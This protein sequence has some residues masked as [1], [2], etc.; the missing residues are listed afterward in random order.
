MVEFR[1]A[2]EDPKLR[3]VV[4][5][6]LAKRHL[7]H[8]QQLR[9][10]CV[11]PIGPQVMSMFHKGL[12]KLLV[13]NSRSDPW[14]IRLTCLELSNTSI[15]LED[16]ALAGI[17]RAMECVDVFKVP[18]SE[19]GKLAFKAL[20]ELIPHGDGLHEQQQQHQLSL[21]GCPNVTSKMILELLE[22]SLRL[23]R[24]NADKVLAS[25]MALSTRDSSMTTKPWACARSLKSLRLEFRLDAEALLSASSALVSAPSPILALDAP[26]KDHETLKEATQHLQ[27]LVFRRLSEPTSFEVLQLKG[28]RHPVLADPLA[29]LEKFLNQGLMQNQVEKP[30]RPLDDQVNPALDLGVYK[31]K[32]LKRMRC[33]QTDTEGHKEGSTN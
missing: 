24:F 13:F 14:N 12:V 28:P 8:L 31:L 26:G 2:L 4:G 19:F 15:Q 11:T 16:N 20:T 9:V 32:T 25:D 1:H 10:R 33:F 6:Y 5:V 7:A 21:A 27:D 23:E 30:P 17:L 29:F 22:S 18:E 3:L